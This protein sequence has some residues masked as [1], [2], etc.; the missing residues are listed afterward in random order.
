MAAFTFDTVE[1]LLMYVRGNVLTSP[2]AMEL[3]D[4]SRARLS[5]LIRDGK[6][7]TIKDNGAHLFY[8][9]HIEAKRIELEELRR[10]YRPFE[11]E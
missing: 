8:K 3:L 4:V 6:I 11:Y 2:E 9:P 10:K 7:D 1:D 5:Q